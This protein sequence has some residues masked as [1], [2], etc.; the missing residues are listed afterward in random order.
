MSEC[1]IKGAHISPMGTNTLGEADQTLG[2]AE[3][4]D[5]QYD[6]MKMQKTGF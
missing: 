5:K 3:M 6:S 2:V 4:T 1:L